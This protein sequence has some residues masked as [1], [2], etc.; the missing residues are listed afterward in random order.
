MFPRVVSP[1][2]FGGSQSPLSS[3]GT[4]SG[5][6]FCRCLVSPMSFSRSSRNAA[7]SQSTFSIVADG[8]VVVVCVGHGAFS[9]ELE[10][11]MWFWATRVGGLMIGCPRVKRFCVGNC[12]QE[13]RL[14]LSLSLLTALSAGVVAPRE[15][16]PVLAARPPSSPP[17]VA[18]SICNRTGTVP[19]LDDYRAVVP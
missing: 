2:C 4:S 11:G 1:M 9:G 15:S 10:E 3:L 6:L 17:A 7:S 5:A 19:V 18:A 14:S 13:T 16:W 8:V 12:E